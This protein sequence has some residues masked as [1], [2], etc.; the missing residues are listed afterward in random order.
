[1]NKHDKKILAESVAYHKAETEILINE[2]LEM[3]KE[4][5]EIIK[6]NEIEKCVHCGSL[7]NYKKGDNIAMRQYY[8]EG[9]GQ[10]CGSCYDGIYGG[11][12]HF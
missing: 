11:N 10:L 2:I 7:T 12:K 4:E 8:I 5:I 6:N 9:A 1:M 3:H